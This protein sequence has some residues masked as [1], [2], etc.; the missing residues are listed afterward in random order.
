MKGLTSSRNTSSVFHT[1]TRSSYLRRTTRQHDNTTTHQHNNTSTQQPNTSTQ[2]HNNTS[3]QQPN[4][5][6]QHNNPTHQHNNPTHQHINTSERQQ[7]HNKSAGQ[8]AWSVTVRCH[9]DVLH[10]EAG[11]DV[12]RGRGGN[13][14]IHQP[15]LRRVEGEM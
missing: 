9:G 6:H 7:T 10:G 4:T 5:S 1:V 15:S 14:S 13:G 12:D 8:T 11:F 2:Q 3:T